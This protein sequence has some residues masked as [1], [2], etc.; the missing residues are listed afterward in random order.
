VSLLDF[1][2]QLESTL[3]LAS[4]LPWKVLSAPNP[5]N[6]HLIKSVVT[7]RPLNKLHSL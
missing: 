1:N 2:E 5:L 6:S 3:I 7:L 4:F